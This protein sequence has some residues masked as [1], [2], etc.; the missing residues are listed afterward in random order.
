MSDSNIKEV[1]SKFKTAG[2][3]FDAGPTGSGHIHKT[4]LVRTAEKDKPDFIIQWINHHVFP[5]VHEMMSNIRRVSR[6]IRKKRKQDEPAEVL[7]VIETRNNKSYYTDSEGNH[8]RMYRKLDP[9]ISYDIV[10][11]NKVAYEAGKAFGQFIGDLRDMP[12]DEIF[13]VI[14][15]FHNIE[16]RFKNFTEAVREDKAQRVREVKEEIE[17]AGRAIEEMLVIPRLEREGGLPV[18]VTHNDTKL[19]NVLFDENDNAVCVID[20]DTVMPGLTLYDFGDT[21]RTAA[22]TAEEDEADL[23][24]ITFS[25]PVFKAY[26]DGFI[27]KTASFLTQEE[28]N[29]LPL[30]ARYMTFIMGLRFLTDYIMGDVYYSIGYKEQNIRRCRAQFRLMELMN[31]KHQEC[32]EIV[33]Q[34]VTRHHRAAGE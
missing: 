12:A 14:P 27:E 28:I 5:P 32:K 8:W 13:P 22:N 34:S 10:P 31:E 9:G 26:S 23:D 25:I 1:F 2:T 20:L 4:F 3:F 21:I 16:K 24:R 6:H 11:N 33:K 29:L 19:N 18:R 17:F 15:D 7:E 30:S